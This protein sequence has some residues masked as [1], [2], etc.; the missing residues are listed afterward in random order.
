MK[1]ASET[2]SSL[3]AIVDRKDETVAWTDTIIGSASAS[4]DESGLHAAT[5]A[6]TPATIIE[7]ARSFAEHVASRFEEIERRDSLPD[8]IV[9][10]MRVAGFPQILV[11]RS[12]GGF[13]LDVDTAAEVVRLVTAA[14]PSV[15]WV[16]GFYIGTPWIACQLPPPVQDRLFVGGRT[17]LLA[18]AI[19]PTLQLEPDGDGYRASGQCL[20]SSGSKHAEF[21]ICTA[22]TQDADGKVAPMAFVIPASDIELLD[23]WKVEGM[24]AT[25]SF[26]F[27]VKGVSVAKDEIIPWQQIIGGCGFGSKLYPGNLLYSRP[28]MLMTNSY[29][30]PLFV[31]GARAAVDEMVRVN[32]GRVNTNSGKVSAQK[33]AMQMRVGR[34]EARVRLIEDCFEAFIGS[35]MAGDARDTYAPADRIALN[36]RVALIV[37]QCRDIVTQATLGSGAHSFKSSSVLQMYL[38]DVT[39]ISIHPGFDPD[40]ATEAHGK[41]LLGLSPDMFI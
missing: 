10:T 37:E 21:I 39:M 18:S 20:W 28:M 27:R 25:G 30:L 19:A 15:G 29:M 31:G 36:A 4:D 13:E 33:T 3:T 38:R 8:D 17:P 6:M 41:L 5:I 40:A 34:L 9:A 1:N 11:P 22:K 35:V 14:C 32:R 12:R 23:S 24:R 16:L 26:D 2:A 7:R